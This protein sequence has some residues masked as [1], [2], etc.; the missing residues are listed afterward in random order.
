VEAVSDLYRCVDAFAGAL[1]RL[2]LRHVCLCP[3]SRS[4]PLALAFARHGGFQLWVHLDERSAGY[5]A[6]GIA[7]AARQPVALL[8]TS[9]TAAANFTPAV[10]EAFYGQAPLLVCTADRPPE[11][12]HVGANQTVEQHGIYGQ[13]SRLTVDMPVPD[14]EPATQRYFALMASR[15]L[16]ACLGSPNG[17]VHLNFPFREPLVPNGPLPDVQR[18]ANDVSPGLDA[19]L[20]PS[21]RQPALPQS[22][23]VAELI[24]RA[25]RGLIVCGGQNDPVFPAAVMQLAAKIGFP[26]L[27]D[28][29]SGVR[30]GSHHGPLVLDSYDALLHAAASGARVD[31][32]LVLR[33]GAAPTSKTLLQFLECNAE[34]PQVLVTD[35]GWTDPALVAGALLDA[36]ARSCCWALIAALGSHTPPAG[37]AEWAGEWRHMD[38]TARAALK[39]GVEAIVE[40]FEGRVL[41]ELA[42]LLPEDAVLVVGNSMPVRDLDTF[43]PGSKRAVRFLAN[44]GA[45]GIDGVVSTALGAAAVNAGPTVLVIGDIS[46][47]HDMNGLLAARRYG[48]DLIIV[49]VNNDGG[50]IFSF[51]PQANQPEHFEHLFGTPHGLDFAPAAAMYGGNFTRAATWPIFA[52]AVRAGLADGGLHIVEVRTERPTNVTLHRALWAQVA[53]ARDLTPGPSPGRRGERD[54]TQPRVP[55]LSAQQGWNGSIQAHSPFVPPL[56]PGEGPG[57]RSRYEIDGLGV[58]IERWGTGRPLVALHGFTG[59]A[60]TWR[61]CLAGPGLAMETFV[62]DLV[63]HGQTDSPAALAHYRMGAVVADLAALLDQLGLERVALLGYSMGGRVALQFAVA[64]PE[65]VS[66]LLLESASPGIADHVERAARCRSD[67]ALAE[68]IERDGVPAFVAEWEAL[69]LFQSQARLAPAA[70]AAQRT[71]R[72]RN[73]ACGLANSLR[74]MGAG[75]QEPIWQALSGLKMPVLLIVGVED[76]KYVT[77]ARAIAGRLQNARTVVV[78]EAG[79]TVHLEQPAVFS[80][81]VRQFV[82]SA[83]D[84]M[85]RQGREDTWR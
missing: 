53:E 44:R 2:G 79:H 12:H 9:G 60:T 31:P 29:L 51:L 62:V 7:K 41:L 13:H 15:A 1:H 75:A 65:R 67:E 71:Q 22:A 54:T 48:L 66:T 82:L 45:S 58:H 49:L 70:W 11:L 76:E 4:T 61:D 68:R 25:Q 46:F 42:D 37:A 14:A 27:A 78:P 30:C 55:L 33:F 36:N 73:N 47:Y 24:R 32:D 69:P 35:A 80:D 3:G 85:A 38:A 64:Y 10:V 18:D 17:P 8:C 16:S 77:L 39:A 28:P 5:F 43:F 40:P 26:V 56:R 21:V 63:G 59:C 57:V 83:E 23:A 6:L 81:A 74:G 34:C 50:G 52:D 84:A 20:M 19:L 72:L